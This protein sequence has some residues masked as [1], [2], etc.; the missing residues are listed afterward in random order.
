MFFFQIDC[1]VHDCD[2][3]AEHLGLVQVVRRE[4]DGAARFAAVDQV[5]DVPEK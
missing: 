5:P 1:L 4:D 3:V 2:P